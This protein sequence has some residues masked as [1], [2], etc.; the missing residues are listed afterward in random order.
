M[1]HQN[2]VESFSVSVKFWS[3]RPIHSFARVLHRNTQSLGRKT[4]RVFECAFPVSY[5][6]NRQI[7][8]RGNR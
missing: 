4:D 7:H 3:L 1:K 8:K 2:G 6:H 5:P